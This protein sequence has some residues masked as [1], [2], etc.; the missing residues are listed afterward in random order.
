M[1]MIEALHRTE[2][3]R[4]ALGG[5]ASLDGLPGLWRRVEPLCAAHRGARASWARA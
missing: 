4:A 3:G 5:L 2:A 1:A